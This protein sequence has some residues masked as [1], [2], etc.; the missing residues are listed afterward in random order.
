MIF[1]RIKQREILEISPEDES[2][3]LE[4]KISRNEDKHVILEIK[5]DISDSAMEIGTIEEKSF[6]E[7]RS[8]EEQ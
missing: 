8:Q 1:S 3:I 2:R 7:Q 4:Y 6:Q 5:I